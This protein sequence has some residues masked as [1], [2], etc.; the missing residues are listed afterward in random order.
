MSGDTYMSV[1]TW[2]ARREFMTM[3]GNIP[4]IIGCIYLTGFKED[5]L[6]RQERIKRAREKV[7]FQG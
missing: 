6:G 4:V 5:I 1:L 7:G 2:L 3:L